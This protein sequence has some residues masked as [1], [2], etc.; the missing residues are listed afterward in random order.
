MKSFLIGLLLNLLIA[1]PAFA[2][3]WIIYH[4]GP[5][6][7]K[8]VDEETNQPI[9]GVA[10]VAV[11]Y[12]ERYGGGA[13][14]IAKFLDAKEAVTDKNGEFEIPS[15]FNFHWWPFAALDEPNLIVF[16]PGY[17]SYKDYNYGPHERVV[18]QLPKATTKKQRM[19][20]SSFDMCETMNDDR[21]MKKL[22]YMWKLR[23]QEWKDLDLMK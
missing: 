2:G 6:K 20:A 21:C 14:P 13:G 23:E 12:L 1:S 3:G 10:V 22:P 5:Y 15:M 11:W 16:K 9:E 7:G 17:R 18:I 8:V 19:D 4:D